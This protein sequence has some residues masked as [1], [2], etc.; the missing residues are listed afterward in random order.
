MDLQ[1]HY[2]KLFI[3]LILLTFSTPT[4][5]HEMWIEPLV[6]SAKSK[7]KITAHLRVGQ[8]FNGEAMYYLPRNLQKLGISDATGDRKIVRVIGDFPI[9]EQTPKSDGLQ[10]LYYLSRATKIT[11]KTSEK[12]QKFLQNVGLDWVYDAHKKAGFPK[13]NFSETYI[14]YAKA[15]MNR[16]TPSGQDKKI[17]LLFEIIAQENPYQLKLKDGSGQLRVQLIWQDKPLAKAQISIFEKPATNVNTTD[18]SGQQDYQD[19]TLTK[20]RTDADGFLLV[21]VKANKS[22]M[23]NSV[24]ITRGNSDTDVIWNSHWA[25][26]TFTILP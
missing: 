8:D 16:G 19:S 20:L 4:F 7:T 24:Q 1:N 21:P 6:A 22:Y 12:F 25:S 9:F 23:L 18:S 26:L 14:R 3:T 11:Y 17:G 2:H 10:I 15:L 13:A 5:A